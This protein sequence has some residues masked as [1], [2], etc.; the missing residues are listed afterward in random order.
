MTVVPVDGWCIQVFHLSDAAS[1]LEVLQA[2]QTA[3][4]TDATAFAPADSLQVVVETA[5]EPEV[6]AQVE[7]VVRSIDRGSRRVHL[8]RGTLE[9][10]P[11]A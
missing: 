3:L 11:A 1:P 7:D 8:S 4:G 10:A 5:D 9:P 6:V 2:V